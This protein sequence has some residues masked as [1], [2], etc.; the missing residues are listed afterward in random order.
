M[1][2]AG[3]ERPPTSSR[4][5]NIIIDSVYYIRGNNIAGRC[6]VYD[7]RRLGSWEL[8]KRKAPGG[9]GG[10]WDHPQQS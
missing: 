1:S 10:R 2:E 9:T 4:S 5:L 3:A 6:R 7:F 8:N